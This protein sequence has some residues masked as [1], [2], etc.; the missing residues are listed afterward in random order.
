[1]LD[2]AGNAQREVELRRHGLAGAAD[3]PLHGQPTGVAD[4]AR[5]RELGPQCIR[6]RLRHRQLV[7][8][9]DA[10]ADG[11]NALRL[12]QVHRLTGFLK[13]RLGTL[14]DRAAIDTDVERTERGGR[15]AFDGLVG[16]ERPNLHRHE[17][18]CGSLRDDVGRQLALEHRPDE[19]PVYLVAAGVLDSRH[20]GDERPIEAGGQ[21]RREVASLIGVRQHDQRWVELSDGLLQR[22]RVAVR[23]VRI[24]CGVVDGHHFLHLRRPE[25]G[26]HRIDVRAE[27][28]N[29]DGRV[30]QLLRG[31]DGFPRRAIEL[32]ASLLSNNENQMTRASS[33]SRR[34]SS[35]AASAGA[36]AIIC[37]FLL[38]S[39]A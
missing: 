19:Y 14:A 17:M 39:G 34:T 33:R 23:R 38:F 7:L 18:R 21:L 10:A 32:A 15:G 35:L 1:M 28:R 27:H 24:E 20:V 5:R 8:I 4:R 12:R 31:R 36:P 22:G 30:A 37:V 3:L 9:L 29:R 2:G 26:R 6:Q 11:D 16:A 25:L 13:R